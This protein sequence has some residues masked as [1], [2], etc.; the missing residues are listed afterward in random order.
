MTKRHPFLLKEKEEGWYHY[1]CSLHPSIIHIEQ[2]LSW[3]ECGLIYVGER[4]RWKRQK[5]K[6]KMFLFLFNLCTGVFKWGE[7]WVSMLSNRKKEGR[8][9]CMHSFLCLFLFSNETQ[10]QIL[11]LVRAISKLWQC[12]IFDKIL[13]ILHHSVNSSIYREDEYTYS[14]RLDSDSL[15]LF[16][17]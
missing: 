3:T 17:E 5:W 15:S 6:A 4:A 11:Y 12:S 7:V 9:R 2:V 1:Y 14:S 8:R 16:L 13:L 10:V